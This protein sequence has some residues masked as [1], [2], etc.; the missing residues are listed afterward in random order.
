MEVQTM[1]RLSTHNHLAKILTTKFPRLKCVF[2][3]HS[4]KIK[5]IIISNDCGFSLTTSRGRFTKIFLTKQTLCIINSIVWFN[6]QS[7]KFNSA[8]N[9]LTSVSN[10]ARDDLMSL[11]S[12][13]RSKRKWNKF[14]KKKKIVPEFA[15]LMLTTFFS[16]KW[17]SNAENFI[18]LTPI[19]SAWG[20]NS[21]KRKFMF[22][23]FELKLMSE[24]YSRGKK[25]SFLLSQRK[26][27]WHFIHL[28]WKISQRK[29]LF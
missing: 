15:S 4:I 17:S 20:V 22:L 25:I 19:K 18:N 5:F 2:N 16:L 11:I 23:P 9:F 26:A 14:D 29:D 13:C 24:K 8:Q 21:A 6:L 28:Q 27:F 7:I 12:C 1:R 3:G 10:I